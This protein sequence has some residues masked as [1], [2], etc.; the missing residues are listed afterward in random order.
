[1]DLRAHC[2]ASHWLR[3][4]QRRHRQPSPQHACQ[5][6]PS[7]TKGA[8]EWWTGLPS[9]R[10]S[11]LTLCTPSPSE[12]ERSKRSFESH[13]FSRWRSLGLAAVCAAPRGTLS[14]MGNCGRTRWLREWSVFVL[15]ESVRSF[16]LVPSWWQCT[17]WWHLVLSIATFAVLH[18]GDGQRVRSVKRKAAAAMASRM[19]CPVGTRCG[20]T[21]LSVAVLHSS[22]APASTDGTRD[23][24]GICGSRRPV[25]MGQLQDSAAILR[26]AGA[27]QYLLRTSF[28]RAVSCVGFDWPMPNLASV[29]SDS[30]CAVSWDSARRWRVLTRLCA[31]GS[32]QSRKCYKCGATEGRAVKACFLAVRQNACS[33]SGRCEAVAQS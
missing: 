3:R 25:V 29:R 1:V 18:H 12:H 30:V 2:A 24:R 16:V 22:K 27:P 10:S 15:L 32:G 13:D 19:R 23:V 8:T 28:M 31:T 7:K 20:G 14:G 9:R 6:R 11:Q 5:L 21:R 17:A 4:R 33:V 26:D